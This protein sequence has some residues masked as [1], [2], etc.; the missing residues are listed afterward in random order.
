MTLTGSSAQKVI[1]IYF[2]VA[3]AIL[4][5]AHLSRVEN[6]SI[7]YIPILLSVLLII[8]I[9]VI[10]RISSGKKESSEEIDGRDENTVL[11]WIFA[12]FILA[13]FV[14][15]PSVLLF[16]MP[17]EKTPLIYLIILTI[18]IVEKT[19]VSAFGFKIRNIGR[20][21]LFGFLFFLILGGVASLISYFAIYCVT[22]QTPVQSYNVLPF[23]LSLPF[24]TL[25]VG[26]SEEGL[27]RGYIQTH[28]EKLYTSNR[29]ILI[30]A[31]LFGVWH[32]VW[33]LYPFNFTHMIFYVGYTFLVGLLF[34]YFYSKTRNLVP[35]VFAHGL[36][37]SVPQGIV[38]SQFVQDVLQAMPSL[39]QILIWGLPYLL[40]VALTFLFIKYLTKEL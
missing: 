6:E 14:R 2:T 12:L 13:L 28:L 32:F 37:N 10:C 27:F 36:V 20:S 26:I 5:T 18:V 9:Y 7:T 4:S 35:L 40:S 17:Y 21:L 8:P 23:L 30:Q 31:I 29:A 11:S 33:D 25:C 22:S 38:E 24:M 16:S 39:N 34:G 1:L 3:A 19:D 15:I